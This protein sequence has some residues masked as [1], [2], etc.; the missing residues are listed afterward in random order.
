MIPKEGGILVT[1]HHLQ[2]EESQRTEISSP[3]K[4]FSEELKLIKRK[5]NVSQIL[6]KFPLGKSIHV[7]NSEKISPMPTDIPQDMQTP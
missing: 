4:P 2:C 3:K 6:N 5:M 1:T 7:I